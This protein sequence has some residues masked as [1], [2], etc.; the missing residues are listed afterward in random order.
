MKR[1]QGLFLFTLSILLYIALWK[2]IRNI[3]IENESIILTSK[4]TRLL[5]PNT[6]LYNQMELIDMSNGKINTFSFDTVPTYSDQLT[7]ITFT[8][9]VQLSSKEFKYWSRYFNNGSTISL[10][11]NVN[12]QSSIFVFKGENSIKN[13]LSGR[14]QREPWTKSDRHSLSY[15]GNITFLKP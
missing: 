4:E 5:L 7:T 13:W 1:L 8:E 6:R 15:E 3:Q 2:L 10:K 11:W 9:S 14:A 12:A